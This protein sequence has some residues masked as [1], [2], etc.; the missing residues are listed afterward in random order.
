MTYLLD[1]QE[2]ERLFFR[3]IRPS[4]FNSWLE[5]H[6]NPITSRH[7]ISDR[8]DAE[9]E[10]RKWYE[11]QFDRYENDRG[12]MNALIE[13]KSNKLIGHCGLLVQTV[14]KLSELEIGYS[15]LPDFWNRGFATEAATKC[16]EFAFENDLSNSLI[17]II[18]LTNIES[19]KVALK[20]GMSLVRTTFYHG[21]AVNIFRI[22]K[23]TAW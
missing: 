9:T 19:R 18:S 8:E 6:K 15:L 12:G 16:R 5:F 14:D 1:G 11:K 23:D 22:D 10:C 3:K 7:W 21:N 2:S 13:K 20:V 17:S 4:D